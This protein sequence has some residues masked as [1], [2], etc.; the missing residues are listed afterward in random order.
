MTETENFTAETAIAAALT[1]EAESIELGELTAEQIEAGMPYID[2]SLA[3]PGNGRRVRLVAT[4]LI[5]LA[6]GSCAAAANP[7]VVTVNTRRNW[8]TPQMAAWWAGKCYGRNLPVKH[9]FLV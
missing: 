5:R 7:Q 1:F 9:R 4:A 3:A 8:T 2:V 6:D